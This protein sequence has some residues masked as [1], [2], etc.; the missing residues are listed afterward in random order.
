MTAKKNNIR[1][2]AIIITAI[3]S[4]V[5]VLVLLNGELDSKI[6]NHPK[7]VGMEVTQKHMKEKIDSVLSKQE[8]LNDKMDNLGDDMKQLLRN[9]YGP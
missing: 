8:V 1:R 7:V 9:E 4:V 5:T 2:N 6:A 3:V